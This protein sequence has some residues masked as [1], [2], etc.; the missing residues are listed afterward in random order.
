MRLNN[1]SSSAGEDPATRHFLMLG[2]AGMV[3]LIVW[4]VFGEDIQAGIYW[5][6]LAEMDL[7]GW[8]NSEF[9]FVKKKILDTKAPVEALLPV[10]GVIVGDA[11]RWPVGILLFMLSVH[12]YR[13]VI[14]LKGRRRYTLD[15]L[16]QHFGKFWPAGLSV[17]KISCK[18]GKQIARGLPTS[19]ISPSERTAGVL[20]RE[21]LG[22][23]I[24]LKLFKRKLSEISSRDVRQD[25][26]TLEEWMQDRGLVVA[27]S[28]PLVK[29][30]L[31]SDLGNLWQGVKA[32]RD[33]ECALLV[34]FV[35]SRCW[36]FEERQDFKL[37]LAACW[38]IGEGFQTSPSVQ[39]KGQ[40]SSTDSLF[41]EEMKKITDCHAYTRTVLMAALEGFREQC[42][43]LPPADFL[44]LKA[45]DRSLWYGLNNL[46]RRTFHVEALALMSHYGQEIS[47]GR[48]S[49]FPLVSS[50]STVIFKNLNLPPEPQGETS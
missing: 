46:G 38:T 39:K 6:R 19:Q 27:P 47:R 24:P 13:C 1:A 3:V 16:I 21:L 17:L 32:L 50:A 4:K 44:W 12:A 31:A 28:L 43:I 42:G 23:F 34:L 15:S 22:L 33:Y 9:V 29:E 36:T 30:V 14:S 26:L 35:A 37:A 18:K 49:S 40:K 41:L 48:K 20:I 11:L 25:A 2:L 45:V 10:F 7:L 8:I 5:I